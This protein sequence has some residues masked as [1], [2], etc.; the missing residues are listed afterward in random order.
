MS[1]TQKPR[2]VLSLKDE[3]RDLL[4]DILDYVP[5][6]TVE[7]KLDEH[8][9]QLRD[10]GC[11]EAYIE[12]SKSRMLKIYHSKG[13]QFTE[14]HARD[15]LVS[16]AGEKQHQGHKKFSEPAGY[17]TVFDAAW[18]KN[19]VLTTLQQIIRF[20]EGQRFDRLRHS[21][22]QPPVVEHR[23]NINPY[24]DKAAENLMLEASDE[25]R[26]QL[27]EAAELAMIDIEKT[28]EEIYQ[29]S[30]QDKSE[31]TPSGSNWA[32]KTGN[33]PASRGIG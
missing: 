32:N 17:P 22:K 26:A 4:N 1:K 19:F 15:L 12:K 11:D 24:L 21:K 31:T 2:I 33:K 20:E 29:Q 10:K 5:V 23:Q 9:K 6:V 28:F 25:R 30:K 7:S 13:F 14:D 18:G 27:K 3:T 16:L 8:C